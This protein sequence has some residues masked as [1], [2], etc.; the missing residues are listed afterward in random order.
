MVISTVSERVSGVARDEVSVE[1][2][3]PHS[4]LG[5]LARPHARPA[6]AWRGLRPRR[7]DRLSTSD[8]PSNWT[9]RRTGD[10]RERHETCVPCGSNLNL[11]QSILRPSACSPDSALRRAALGH[12]G[13][14]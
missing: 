7:L 4:A 12:S 3:R 11:I 13:L 2:Y 14:G 10:S 8:L 5:S 6:L 1:A 9:C